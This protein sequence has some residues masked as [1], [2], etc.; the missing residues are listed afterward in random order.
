MTPGAAG[1]PSVARALSSL[2]ELLASARWAVAV[3]WSTNAWLLS[4]AAAFSLARGLLPAGLALTARGLVNGTVASL[5]NGAGIGPLVPWLVLGLLLT[6]AEALARLASN[7]FTQRLRDDINCRITSD[8]LTHASRL[9]V[10]FF[11][12]PRFQDVLQRA[13]QDPADHISRFLTDT[14]GVAFN[15]MQTAS[16]LAI[17]MVIEPWLVVVLLLFA[18]PYLHFQWRLATRHYAIEHSRAT[19]RRWANYFVARLTTQSSVGEVKLLHLAPLLIDKFRALMA[20]FRDQDHH[21]Y[22]RGFRGSSAF[23]VVSTAAIYA[24]FVHVSYRVLTGALTVGDLAI[25]GGATNRLRNTM[26][27]L[28]QEVASAME[29]TLYISNVIE[30]L[31]AEPAAPSGEIAVSDTPP[32]EIELRDVFFT[33]PGS[34]EPALAGVSLHIR[35]GETVAIVGENGAGKSTLVKLIARLYDPNRGVVLFDGIDLKEFEREALHRQIAFVFQSFGRYE[36]SVADNIAYGD[37]QRLLHDRGKVEDIARRAGVHDTIVAMP[38][39]Y[40]TMLGRTFGEYDLSGGQWQKIAMA[41]AF[42]REA[43]LLILDEPTSNL[44]ARAEYDLFC[45]F[46][47]LAHGRTTIIVSHRFSTVSMANRILVMERGR[48]VEAGT[49]EEL[50]AMAGNYA[51]LY[52]LHRR[53]HAGV[54]GR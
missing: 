23:V 9:D 52:E 40:D 30:F 35:P 47:D 54:P 12:D 44:D 19:K 13:K 6:L 22:G 15:T 18:A 16:M 48:I 20:E 17:L 46:Q 50:L 45:R 24:M 26:E 4:G 38:R 33:Y 41:R 31:A 39:G 53:Q 25:F 43:A 51:N 21:L 10:A 1:R 8:I 3:A 29:Q 32:A 14:L 7:L 49:H 42:A 5:R 11:E 36:A 37:W 2:Q 27:S 34:V 28:I